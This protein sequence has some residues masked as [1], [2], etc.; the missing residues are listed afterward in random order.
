[1]PANTDSAI[2]NRLIQ[3]ERDDLS[4]DA[5]RSILRIEFSEIDKARMHELAQRAQEGTLSESEQVEI[6]SF[7]RV[8]RLLDLMHSKARRSLKRSART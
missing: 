3:P 7:C 1:M 8:G 4:P 6:D 2:W 5:A